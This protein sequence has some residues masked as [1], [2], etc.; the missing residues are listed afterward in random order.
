MEDQII[1]ASLALAFGAA[2]AIE[3]G[4][5]KTALFTYLASGKCTWKEGITIALSSSVTHSLVV[6]GIAFL[7]H[8]LLSHVENIDKQ[9]VIAL[10]YISAITICLIGVYIFFKKE[11]SSCSHCDSHSHGETQKK[12][13]MASGLLGFATGLVPCP[14]VVVAYLAGLSTGNTLL[15]FQ[16]VIFFAVGMSISLVGLVIVFS[17][18]GKKMSSL[19]ESKS[20][21][22]NWNKIQ[23]MAFL[24]IGLFTAFYH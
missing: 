8:S 24:A 1:P 13:L 21:N 10:R 2:H 12:S 18:G 22:F 15:G 19:L 7:S 9:I 16:S 5:G 6:L 23:A 11:D 20:L 3:P 17:I 14:S 4:H